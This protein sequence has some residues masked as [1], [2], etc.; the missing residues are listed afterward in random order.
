MEVSIACVPVN[1]IYIGI[2]IFFYFDWSFHYLFIY[3]AIRS[4]LKEF[5]NYR[6]PSCLYIHIYL[7]ILRTGRLT[8]QR[9]TVIR[10]QYL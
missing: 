10:E 5:F 1:G 9:T 8:F 4:I 6:S 2:Y 7:T 3:F